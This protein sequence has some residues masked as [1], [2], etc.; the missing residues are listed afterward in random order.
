MKV[1]RNKLKNAKAKA[2]LATNKHEFKPIGRNVPEN[3]QKGRLTCVVC[4]GFHTKGNWK[5]HQATNKHQASLESKKIAETN[6]K[7]DE[8][9][10]ATLA[11]NSLMSEV[12]DKIE[13][14]IANFRATNAEAVKRQGE[15]DEASASI[16]KAIAVLNAKLTKHEQDIRQ[17]IVA[18]VF[19][20]TKEVEHAKKMLLSMHHVQRKL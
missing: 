14:S 12:N 1:L 5:E 17:D 7:E 15:S 8:N 3:K 6:L 2:I 11:R 16:K 9:A 18:N 4:G 20:F 13:A 10:A 19:E